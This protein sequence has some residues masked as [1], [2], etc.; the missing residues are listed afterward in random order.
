MAK[1]NTPKIQFGTAGRFDKPRV[2]AG[3]VGRDLHIDTP[4]TNITIGYR[5][6]NLIADQIYPAIP[7]DKQNNLYYIWTQA[8]FFNIPN[9]QRAPGA[10]AN[11]I[12]FD[13]S[14]AS[15]FCREYALAMELPLED[16]ANADAA[17]NLRESAANFVVDKLSLAWEDRLAVALTTT[18]NV[19]SSVTLAGG[20]VWSDKTNSDPVTNIFTGKESIR[21]TTG[22]EANEV[23]F[24]GVAWNDF[25]QHPD[26]IDFVR[27]KGD[28]TG[29]GPVTQQQVAAAFEVEKVLV[30]KGVKNTADEGAPA[31]YTDI[32]STACIILHVAQNPGLMIPTHGYT[33]QWTPPGLPGPMAVDRYS[34]RRQRTETVEVSHYQDER[35]IAANLGYLI[36]GG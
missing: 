13:V 31:A 9:A 28:N 27:G 12:G 29:G 20:N 18:T 23:I 21:S 17:L 19:G 34:E 16:L 33:F 25:R 14:S 5:P 22:Y 8:D 1:G 36:L 26:I 3:A 10:A 24:S 35:V 15:Y 32:W 7:V 4:L 2:Y 11:R 30:G 6:Q